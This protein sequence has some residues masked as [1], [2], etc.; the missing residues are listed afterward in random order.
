MPGKRIPLS[1]RARDLVLRLAKEHDT[2]DPEFLAGATGYDVQNIKALLA[3]RKV[4]TIPQ[5]PKTPRFIEEVQNNTGLQCR[6]IKQ[7]SDGTSEWILLG[8]NNI[9]LMLLFGMGDLLQGCQAM[10]PGH[11]QGLS[12]PQREA[13]TNK[14]KLPP[15]E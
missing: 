8:P 13:R 2:R 10:G 5:A 3:E 11:I 12:T 6:R 15:E 7:L 9:A 14:K 1:R 4:A